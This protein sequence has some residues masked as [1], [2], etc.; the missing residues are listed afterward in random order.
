MV[1]SP[2]SVCSRTSTRDAVVTRGTTALR[3]KREVIPYSSV[4]GVVSNVWRSCTVAPPSEAR[5]SVVPVSVRAI[6][7]TGTRKRNSPGPSVSDENRAPSGRSLPSGLY[8]SLLRVQVAP[9]PTRNV[10]A[11][12]VRASGPAPAPPGQHSWRRST[13]RGC[14]AERGGQPGSQLAGR[15]DWA[16]VHDQRVRRS[17]KRASMFVFRTR[18]KLTGIR[19]RN[20]YVT[21]KTG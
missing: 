13:R 16:R 11:A 3:A 7:S 10:P 17:W 18:A 21:P 6:D 15:A 9:T 5:K 12:G 19:T 14:R 20:R 2:P 1:A 4:N 8:V